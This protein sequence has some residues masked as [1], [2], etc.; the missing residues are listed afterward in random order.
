MGECNL[1]GQKLESSWKKA[2]ER[3]VTKKAGVALDAQRFIE[4]SLNTIAVL[5]RCTIIAASGTDLIYCGGSIQGPA[6]RISPTHIGFFG[7]G[8][9]A[10][11]GSNTVYDYAPRFYHKTNEPYSPE[12]LFCPASDVSFTV[13]EAVYVMTL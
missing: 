10:A 7:S 3:T 5:V 13:K 6:I 9:F 4:Y 11:S 1:T 8:L 12:V 2:G